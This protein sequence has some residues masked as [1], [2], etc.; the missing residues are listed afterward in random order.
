MRLIP[1]VAA[2]ILTAAPLAAQH[3]HDH[4]SEAD[5]LRILHAWTPATS[6]PEALIYM[7]IENG[8]DHALTL[9]G[10]ETEDG[11]RADLVGYEYVNGV[12]TW[13][14]LPEMPVAAGQHLDLEPRGLALR[15]SNLTAPLA[16]GDE[17]E[18]EVMFGDLH[19]D[20]HVEV[21]AAGATA[22][23]HAGHSH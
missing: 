23:R 3:G 7:E 13:Q 8:S 12:E 6:G 15:L 4:L 17:L 1:L 19:L 21:E 16:E 22:H 20:V 18:I 10:A 2:L 11:Q 14:V 5:G 9:T